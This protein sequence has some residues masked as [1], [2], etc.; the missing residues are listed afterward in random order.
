MA[1]IGLAGLVVLALAAGRALAWGPVE[2]GAVNQM[3]CETAPACHPGLVCDSTNTNGCDTL[4]LPGRGDGGAAGFS[5]VCPG[6]C[7]Q[8]TQTPTPTPTPTPHNLPDNASCNDSRQCT[9][10][11]CNGGVCAEGKPAPAVSNHVGLFIGAGLLLAGLWS[12][13]RIARRG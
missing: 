3:C 4:V 11:L 5:T 2:C 6:T 1:R 8:P 10:T 7:V 9:S 13:R 12:V